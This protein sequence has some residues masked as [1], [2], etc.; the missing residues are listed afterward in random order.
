MPDRPYLIAD[1]HL[2]LGF[3]AIQVNRDLTQPA[4]TVRVHDSE[5]VMRSFGSC[6]VTFPELRRGNVGIIFG[7]MMSRTDPND[8]WTRTGMYC[9]DQ[10]HGVGRGHLAY[11]Q[12]MEREGVVRSSAIRGTWTKR[13][14]PGKTPLRTRLSAWW[15]PWKAPTPSW[16]RP[17]FPNGT[18]WGS[19]S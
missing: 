18:I 7:T 3:S 9:Q 1:S 16:T 10:C 6:T 13:W 11:Y 12:A 14:P 4:A 5:P 17:R 8:R 19:A 15:W 2:D